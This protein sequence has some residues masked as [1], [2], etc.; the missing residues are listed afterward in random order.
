L[1]LYN[2]VYIGSFS[3]YV[4]KAYCKLQN[5]AKFIKKEVCMQNKLQWQLAQTMPMIRKTRSSIR[6]VLP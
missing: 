4:S 6:H 2:L 5:K 3:G 1:A